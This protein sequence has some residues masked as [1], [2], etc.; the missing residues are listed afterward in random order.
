MVFVKKK[1]ILLFSDGS[2][3]IEK[4]FIKTFKKVNILNKDHKTLLFN[5]KNKS[6]ERDSKDS[7]DFKAKFL[8]F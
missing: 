4:T 3:V 5:K 7:K 6:I 8:K 2:L 1:Q